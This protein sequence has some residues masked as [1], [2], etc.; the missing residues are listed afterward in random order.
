MVE[1]HGRLSPLER[2]LALGELVTSQFTGGP[3]APWYLNEGF[4]GS[5]N[6]FIELAA[7]YRTG[8][9][10]TGELVSISIDRTE[11]EGISPMKWQRRLNIDQLAEMGDTEAHSALDVLEMGVQ[12][13]MAAKPT[14]DSVSG[15]RGR[16]E[17]LFFIPIDV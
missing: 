13:A 12:E 16:A 9:D 14:R 1:Q 7:L 6:L 11:D 2:F 5:G 10:D 8:G 4:R 3:E 17:Q 15:F